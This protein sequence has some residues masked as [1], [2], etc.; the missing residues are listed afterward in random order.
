MIRSLGF[1]GRFLLC[2][3]LVFIGCSKWNNRD[4]SKYYYSAPYNYTIIPERKLKWDDFKGKQVE[5]SSRT[6]KLYWKFYYTYDSAQFYGEGL[7]EPNLK[8]FCAIYDISWVKEDYKT[9]ELLNHE[10]GHF[11]IVKF[12]AN[13]FKNK[14]ELIKPLSRFNWKFRVDSVYNAIFTKCCVMNDK[15]EK[16]TDYGHDKKRQLIWDKKISGFL[17]K[18]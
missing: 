2:F 5:G 12:H 15:Y 6:A 17:K 10:Q 11:D 9:P 4:V 14:T 13:E 7:I 16:Q 8:V 18:Q 3:I 1:K